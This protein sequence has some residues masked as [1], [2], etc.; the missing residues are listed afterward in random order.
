MS[1]RRQ[2]CTSCSLRPKKPEIS[3]CGFSRALPCR[4]CPQGKKCPCLFL[5]ASRTFCTHLSQANKACDTLRTPMN[6]Q[7]TTSLMFP[8]LKKK[9]KD[10][11][12]PKDSWYPMCVLTELLILE[13]WWEHF[14]CS[15]ERSWKRN[16][17]KPQRPKT[18]GVVHN[19][20]LL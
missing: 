18:K 1:E 20:L 19:L 13:T 3:H 16:S 15:Q 10:K 2:I 14:S 5:I 12:G 4:S 8:R 7:S 11:Y 17:K 6:R 9:K